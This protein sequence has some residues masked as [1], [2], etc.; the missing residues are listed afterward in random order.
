MN[1]YIYALF[2][3]IS[4]AMGS[5]FFTHYAKKY[6]SLWINTYKAMV[7]AI[8][9]GATVLAGSG[10]SDLSFYSFSLFFI[11]GFIALGIGDIFLIKAFS[12]IGPGRTMV[13][14]GFHP[15]V[16]GSISYFAFDQ[17]LPM[18]KLYGIIFFILC[19]ITFSVEN[20]RKNKSW[21]F[22]GLL[23][24]LAGMIFD[25][26][27]VT[28]TRKAFDLSGISAI[29]GNFYRC[30]GALASF[31]VISRFLP[32]HFFKGLKEMKLTSKAYVSFGAFV[33]TYLA[34]SFYLEAIKVAHLAS[35]SAISI[36]SVIFASIFESIFNKSWPGRYLFVAL[37][38]F[39]IGMKFI[40]GF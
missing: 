32:F 20:F 9:F 22:G 17:E 39:G 34:L 25:A 36:T 15:L 5:I 27:G 26:V 30:L 14:F 29:E 3:N 37:I 6:S 11:S 4:F 7:A 33:G 12:L 13:L 16:V 24:A 2:S 1:P 28:I 40:L 21:E 31:I 8:L 23:F 35:V 38:F 10:F 18:S 19:L